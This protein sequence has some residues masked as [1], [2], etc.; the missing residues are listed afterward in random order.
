ARGAERDDYM[1]EGLPVLP[2]NTPF[3]RL[4]ELLGVREMTPELFDLVRPHLT[5]SGTGRINLAAAGRPVLLSLAGMTE[6]AVTLIV[7]AQQSSRRAITLMEVEQK[8]SAAARALLTPE[9]PALQ[10]RTVT[11]TQELE[12]RSEGWVDGSP[13][14]SLVAAL[15][16]RAG[17]ETI[18]I[19]R[20]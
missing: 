18:V 10:A 12:L 14:R 4:D 2:S 8:L 15:V 7:R 20:R 5:L 16:V 6:E 9:L 1:K 13:V 3:E 17:A 11:A 19:G